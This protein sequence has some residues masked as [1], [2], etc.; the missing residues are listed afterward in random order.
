MQEE[1]WSL[2]LGPIKKIT[3]MMR[4]ENFF[5]MKKKQPKNLKKGT[6]KK[7]TVAQI[8]HSVILE[9][10]VK[11]KS[12]LQ[13]AKEQGYTHNYAK[14]G[15]ITKSR[16]WQ[17]ILQTTFDDE[18]LSKIH[19]ELLNSYTVKSLEFNAKMFNEESAR[20]L[21]KEAGFVVIKSFFAFGKL[22]VSCIVPDREYRD[23]ALDKAYK[24]KKVYTDTIDLNLNK[25]KDMSDAELAEVISQGKKFFKK[26]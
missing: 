25:F 10:M 2:F 7:I 21:C 24:L 1:R 20:E 3:P 23:R 5:D 12:L 18:K 15:N 14:S 22:V 8:K 26:G 19:E 4:R 9:K 6:Q 16:S 13:A 11:G 17:K